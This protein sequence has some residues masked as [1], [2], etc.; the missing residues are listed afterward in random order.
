MSSAPPLSAGVLASLFTTSFSTV[1]PPA[2][3]HTHF[4]LAPKPSFLGV[5]PNF[6][7]A[8]RRFFCESPASFGEAH[9]LCLVHWAFAQDL[10]QEID[11]SRFDVLG[12]RRQCLVG[13][14]GDVI[15]TPHHG[16]G[17]NAVG[18]DLVF[19][20]ECIACAVWAKIVFQ[21]QEEAPSGSDFLRHKKDSPWRGY[22]A[23]P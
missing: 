10:L 14:D 7:R 18:D 1:A 2:G 3:T 12:G 22:P 13:G 23:T 16:R 17:A 15:A 5:M 4:P 19:K 11:G 6:S 9:D 8:V 20:L 21:R